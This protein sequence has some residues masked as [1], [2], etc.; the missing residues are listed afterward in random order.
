MQDGPQFRYPGIKDLLLTI[1][2]RIAAQLPEENP[3]LFKQC[4]E[5]PDLFRSFSRGIGSLN[6]D[7]SSAV[8]LSLQNTQKFKRFPFY[9]LREGS[10]HPQIIGWQRNR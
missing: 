7:N 1:D 8:I 4:P 2:N 6:P 3:V 10:E 5:F 9:D